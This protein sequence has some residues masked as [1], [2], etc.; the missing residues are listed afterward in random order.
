MKPW[1]FMDKKIID[2]NDLPKYSKWIDIIMGLESVAKKNK[3]EQ[4]LK[5]EYEYEKWNPLLKLVSQNESLKLEDVDKLQYRQDNQ[6]CIYY[7]NEFILTSSYVAYQIYLEIVNQNLSPL[8]GSVSSLVELGSGYGNIILNIAL[9]NSSFRK[10]LF[11][12]EFAESGV[13]LSQLLANR[14]KI[15]LISGRCNFFN[16]DFPDFHIPED[17]LIFFSYALVSIP[18]MPSEFLDRLLRVKPKYIVLFEPC[19]ELFDLT[20]IHGILKIRY[21][22]INDYNKNIY[23]YFAKSSRLNLIKIEKNVFGSNPLLPMSVMIFEVK[24]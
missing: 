4:E 11:A 9:R 5:R 18:E 24:K 21:I 3:T 7:R 8:L 20:T 14:E 1:F 17:S 19:K 2:I 15:E 6:I 16:L 22:E 13:A 10:K 12:G 23:S